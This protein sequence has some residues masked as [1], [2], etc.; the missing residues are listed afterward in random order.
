MVCSLL[1]CLSIKYWVLSIGFVGMDFEYLL[2]LTIT[3]DIQKMSKVLF[4]FI[5]TLSSSA[6]AEQ[7]YFVNCLGNSDQLIFK[8]VIRTDKN[9]IV[10]KEYGF[11]LS[12]TQLTKSSP[13]VGGINGLKKIGVDVSLCDGKFG[14][15]I[16]TTSQETALSC[17]AG[18]ITKVDKS[19]DH[20]ETLEK[21]SGN[22]YQES[23]IFVLD[24]AKVRE[25]L[26]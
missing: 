3:G 16:E 22:N 5:I 2:S 25:L 6:F 4:L 19:I 7:N 8:G 21:F 13:L 20:P 23:C 1:M 14:K 15:I 18:Q 9:Q 12:G 10:P 11:A 17:G 24:S 26:K